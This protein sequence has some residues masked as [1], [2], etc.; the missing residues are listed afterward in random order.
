ME[1][2]KFSTVL[3]E[4]YP[5]NDWHDIPYQE[6]SKAVWDWCLANDA[7]YYSDDRDPFIYLSKR[8]IQEAN[9]SEVVLE[10]LS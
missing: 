2:I 6:L 5:N 10:D 3:D 9:N 7:Y 1:V 4:L 8:P